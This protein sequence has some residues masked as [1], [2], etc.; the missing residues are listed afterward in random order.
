MISDNRVNLLRSMRE[1]N[2][3]D[4]LVDFVRIEDGDAFTCVLPLDF[5][6][7]SFIPNGKTAWV[8]EGENSL[9][10]EF[11]DRLKIKKITR[12]NMFFYLMDNEGKGYSGSSALKTYTELD[13]DRFIVIQDKSRE[14][15]REAM[16]DIIDISNVPI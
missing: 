2:E 16:N 7:S 3:H 11:I 1:T 10:G 6:L 8:F 4:E 14:S 13:E 12:K 5:I 9:G 15:M